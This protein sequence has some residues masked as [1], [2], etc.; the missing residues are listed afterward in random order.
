VAFDFLKLP[1]PAQKA[2]FAHMDRKRAHDRGQIS[3]FVG[4]LP[5][6]PD[7]RG[8]F[9]GKLRGQPRRLGSGARHQK[10]AADKK[11]QLHH[12]GT[13]KQESA[14][15]RIDAMRDAYE[16]GHTDG[17]KLSGG[18][19]AQLVKKIKLSDGREAVLKRQ[20]PE[21]TRREYLAGRVANALG[22]KDITVAQVSDRD[23]V[24]NF[25]EGRSGAMQMVDNARKQP[26]TKLDEKQLLRLR[27][28]REI[29]MLDWLSN[30]DDR[31]ALN[32]MVSPD[33]K[34]VIPIDHGA[35]KFDVGARPR[36]PTSPFVDEWMRPQLMKGFRFV[37]SLDPQWTPEELAQVRTS[38]QDLK[39]EFQGR[40]VE[41]HSAMLKRLDQL[42]K[43]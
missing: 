37:E 24:M 4:V 7:G 28:G 3:G 41:W 30:N 42:E 31:H 9:S 5:D 12:A 13:Q 2:A 36:A 11:H 29:A 8:E 43:A 19:R 23:V 38:I 6:K 32:Y 22:I 10:L 34:S 15:Q 1:R 26:G 33:G 18:I 14:Q 21:E 39:P 20:S 35:A 16:K 27:N 17:E 40:E 25:V